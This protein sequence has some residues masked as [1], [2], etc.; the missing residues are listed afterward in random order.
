MQDNLV[1]VRATVRDSKG[2]YVRGLHEDDF[3]LFEGK[4]Q[5]KITYFDE[6]DSPATS[7]ASPPAGA[8][9]GPT[10]ALK[11][12]APAEPVF[13]DRYVA[14]FFDDIHGDPGDLTHTQRAVARFLARGIASSDRFGVFTSS[15]QVLL[16]FTADRDALDRALSSLKPSPV[17]N[18]GATHCPDIPD[19]M[20]YRMTQ[21]RDPEARL[22]ARSEVT[23][24]SR[25]SAGSPPPNPLAIENQANAA[26]ALALD[27]ASRESLDTLDALDHLIAHLGGMP[28]RRSL[29]IVSPGFFT[30]ATAERVDRLADEALRQNVVINALDAKGLVNDIAAADVVTSNAVLMTSVGNNAGEYQRMLSETRLEHEN[31]MAQ[32][33]AATGGRFFHNSNDFDLGVREVTAPPDVVYTLAFAP[34]N[35]NYDGSF[36]KIRVE[37]AG[38][39][40]A[41]VEARRGYFAP[42]AAPDAARQ[43]QEAIEQA[44]TSNQEVGDIPEHMAMQ[45]FKVNS[46]EARLRVITHLDLQFLDMRR[47]NGLNVDHLKMAAVVLDQNGFQQQSQEKNLDLRL[48][49]DKLAALRKSG[50][51]VEI[52]FDLK[53]GLYTVREVFRDANGALSAMSRH[54]NLSL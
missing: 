27:R 53:P 21:L 43:E 35:V 3:R 37:V 44:L 1:L 50:L 41:T 22:L 33:A 48:P 47:E 45:A 34:H 42:A 20:A 52:T 31:V 30:M 14:F 49:D 2:G 11:E 23:N 32:A 7:T 16:D 26:A 36:H 17:V 8:T 38:Q 29:V 51:T 24:C 13:P 54:V 6:Q 19:L 9:S 4:N 39:P 15:G 5:Q 10:G 46:T 18:F 25:D 12:S 40:H 28:G